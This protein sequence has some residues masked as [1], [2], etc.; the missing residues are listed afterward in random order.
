MSMENNL[1]FHGDLPSR[2]AL[3]ATMREMGFAFTIDPQ[4][5]PLDE[6]QGFMPMTYGDETATGVEFDLWAGR[7]ILDDI[8][9]GRVLDPKFDRSANFRWGGSMLECAAGYAVAAAMAKLTGGVMFDFDARFLQLPEILSEAQAVLRDA[10]AAG[11]A[12]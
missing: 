3:T 9:D 10:I 2:E 7:E 12:T 8:L 1:F 4:E 5:F 11:E 6:Q